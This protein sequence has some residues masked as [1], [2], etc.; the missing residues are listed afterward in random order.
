MGLLSEV[1]G[2]SPWHRE[3]CISVGRVQSHRAVLACACVCVSVSVMARWLIIQA[4]LRHDLSPLHS[5]QSLSDKTRA[6]TFECTCVGM[7]E[8]VSMRF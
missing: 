8:H 7:C 1:S 5:W 2:L 3:E 6:T 4:S